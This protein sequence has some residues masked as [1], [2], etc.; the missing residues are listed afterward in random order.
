MKY[1]RLQNRDARWAMQTILCLEIDPAILADLLR[2]LSIHGEVLAI[3]AGQDVSSM[4]DTTPIGDTATLRTLLTAYGLTPRQCDLVVLDMQG[5]SRADIAERYG[6]SASTVKKY[7]SAI[8]RRLGVASRP[9][10][11]TW[12]LAQLVCTPAP[13]WLEQLVRSGK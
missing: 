12:V 7:W 9:A 11:R 8:Y 6:V 2:T 5:R 13:Q 4:R 3:R 1:P 10:L